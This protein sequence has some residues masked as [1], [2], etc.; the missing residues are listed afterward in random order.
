M[1]GFR[2][3]SLSAMAPAGLSRMEMM[4]VSDRFGTWF[5]GLLVAAIFA[6][7]AFAIYQMPSGGQVAIHWG[8]DNRADSWINGSAIHLINPIVALTT[9]FV[10]SFFHQ[11][12][13]TKRQLAGVARARLSN[14]LLIQLVVQLLMALYLKGS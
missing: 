12:V 9:W 1:N 10:M 6:V 4:R 7:A 3:K 11:G 8:P 2:K 14:L 13:A 5:N